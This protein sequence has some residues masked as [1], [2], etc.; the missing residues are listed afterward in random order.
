MGMYTDFVLECH[1]QAETPEQTIQTLRYMLKV[2]GYIPELP[3]HRLFS[4]Q[5][6]TYMLWSG[7]FKPTIERDADTMLWKLRINTSFKN[8]DGEISEFLDW[9][10]PFLATN[11]FLGYYHY[12]GDTLPRLIYS[13]QIGT[14]DFYK[15]KSVREIVSILD[16]RKLALINIDRNE[17]Q[18][19]A[20]LYAALNYTVKFYESKE[21]ADRTA[22]SAVL[23]QIEMMENQ[24][25]IWTDREDFRNYL[26][27]IISN[28]MSDRGFN[29]VAEA[30]KNLISLLNKEK[31]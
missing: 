11:D 21:D 17:W 2:T 12:E 15:D 16:S 13:E 22:V 30:W 14:N 18:K 10:K 31:I 20:E 9:I 23:E 29:E 1:L 3:E 19:I 26:D 8:Y 5:R 6:W 25:D 7:Y 24:M 28:F 27:E 4:T